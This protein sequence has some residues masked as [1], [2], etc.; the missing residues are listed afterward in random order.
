VRPLEAIDPFLASGRRF[1][2]DTP[3]TRPSK[4]DPPLAVGDGLAVQQLCVEVEG[5]AYLVGRDNYA[6]ERR[7]LI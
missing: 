3:A 4:L 6:F 7:A 2:S 1:Q 5:A